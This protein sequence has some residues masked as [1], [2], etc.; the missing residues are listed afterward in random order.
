LIFIGRTID[1]PEVR[2]K[3]RAASPDAAPACLAQTPDKLDEAIA[4]ADSAWVYTRFVPDAEQV[5][6]IHAAG[7]H[8][9]VSGT[10]V[11]GHEPANWA[12]A[13]DAGADLVLTDYPLEARAAARKP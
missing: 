4:D 9:F 5:K 2:K 1:N 11:I 7:K 10:L 12:K 3:L 8:V 13:R 6:K